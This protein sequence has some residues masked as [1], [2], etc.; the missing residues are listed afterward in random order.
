[1]KDVPGE[2]PRLSCPSRPEKEGPFLPRMND[3]G[4]LTRTGET[5]LYAL[6]GRCKERANGEDQVEG[7]EQ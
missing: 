4:I 3:G 1:M 2:S 5:I 7:T 6:S